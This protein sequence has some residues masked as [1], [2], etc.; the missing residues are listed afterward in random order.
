MTH[1]LIRVVWFLL[2]GWWIGIIWFCISLLTM[3]T[4]IGFLPGALSI[5]KTWKIMF[6]SSSEK[7]VV[8]NKD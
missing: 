2:I 1:P 6:L 7:V 8:E 5:S 4:G 3:L